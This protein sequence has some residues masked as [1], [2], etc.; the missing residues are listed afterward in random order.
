MKVRHWTY[1]CLFA[2]AAACADDAGK[3]FEDGADPNFDR[4]QSSNNTAGENNVVPEVEDDFQFA[5]PAVLGTNVFVANETL[6]SVAVIDSRSLA[7]RTVPVGFNPT[8]VVGPTDPAD[9]AQIYVLNEGSSTVSIIDPER[10]T[11]KNVDVLRR[12][13]ALQ[14]SPDGTWALAY[15]DDEERREG[16][17]A[18]DLS[19]ATLIKADGEALQLA[20][21]F[22]IERV[23]FTEDS[24]AALILSDDGVSVVTADEISDDALV[25]PVAVLPPD[26]QRFDRVDREVTLDP[27]GE[28]AVARVT[29]YEGVVLT[30]LATGV[31]W[32]V[33]LPATPTD[34]DWVDGDTPR[35]LGMLREIDYAFIATIPDGLIAAA[36]ALPQPEDMGTTPD[37]G[38]DDMGTGDMGAG[39]MGTGDMADVAPDTGA[40]AQV[41]LPTMPATGF[42]YLAVTEPNMGAAQVAPSSTEALL[43]STIGEERRAVLVDL[44]TLGQRGLSFEKGVRG[45]I[46]DD[47]GN[48]FVVLHSREE[49]QIPVGASPADPEY[50]ARS[51]GIS[52]VDVET[53]ATRLVL[54]EQKPGDATLYTGDGVADQLYMIFELPTD[55]SADVPALRD[56]LRV[57]LQSFSTQ[58]FR[59]PS[60]PEGI[61]RIDAAQKV[62]VNQIHPQGRITFVDVVTD[63][64]QTVTGYQLN[65]GID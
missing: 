25:P 5:E 35:V 33:P 36:D 40:S 44:E 43:F 65:A 28:W 42:T 64:R 54:T 55:S 22:R 16:E 3:S 53:A 2:L 17:T 32:R 24:S 39:D 61:G 52:I 13:N 31:Q 37:M 58:T 1:I 19:A 21:G 29:T 14:A 47:D 56:V 46:A 23:M 30:D 4:N 62:F 57:D 9:G 48:T 6:N 41:D 63:R 12:A 51:W 38:A 10:L 8:H 26:L 15:Y 50:I 20:V 45:A 49:G 27:D 18:G 59:V 60:L 11:P 7:I 34:L